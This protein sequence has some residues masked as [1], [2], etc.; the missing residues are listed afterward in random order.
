MDFFP[1]FSLRAIY[2]VLFLRLST[3]TGLC[4]P[5]R[6]CHRRRRSILSSPLWRATVRIMDLRVTAAITV[7]LQLISCLQGDQ[8]EATTEEAVKSL[9]SCKALRTMLSHLQGAEV[10]TRLPLK[11]LI[12]SM[13]RLQGGHNSFVLCLPHWSTRLL[14]SPLCGWRYKLTGISDYWLEHCFT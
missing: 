5:S 10:D 14:S 6:L 2:S 9:S 7:D 13:L 11:D 12:L 1:S 8:A 3:L 4:C